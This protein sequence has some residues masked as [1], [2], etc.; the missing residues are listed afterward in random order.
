M[1]LADNLNKGKKKLTKFQSSD[2]GNRGKD[3]PDIAHSFQRLGVKRDRIEENQIEADIHGYDIK[4]EQS[5]DRFGNSRMLKK[6]DQDE[7]DGALRNGLRDNFM[8]DDIDDLF[9][10]PLDQ[11]IADNDIPERLQ[12]RHKNRL[13]PSE[14]SLRQEAQW[15]YN[16][17]WE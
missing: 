7:Q 12:I 11:E 9:G 14:E 16:I 2:Q 15:I 17:I 10:T 1:L 13:N 3:E 4:N 6:Q 5:L 8:T